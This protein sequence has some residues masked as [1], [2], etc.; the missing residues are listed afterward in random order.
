MCRAQLAG[1]AEQAARFEGRV[2]VVA[3]TRDG[4]QR[5]AR[6]RAELPAAVTILSDPAERA[7]SALCEGLAHCQ[8]LLDADGV[9]RWAAWS[10]SWSEATPAASLLQAAYRLGGRRE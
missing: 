7:P 3:V 5:L 4:P 8:V 6:M 10:E 1:L 2:R 9:V